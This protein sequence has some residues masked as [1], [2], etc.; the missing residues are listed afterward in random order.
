MKRNFV[1]SIII[2]ITLLFSTL[3]IAFADDGT[4]QIYS[5]NDKKEECL[6]AINVIETE[7]ALEG[8]SIEKEVQLFYNVLENDRI[9]QGLDFSED[10]LDHTDD[11]NRILE[12]VEK[13]ANTKDLN[14]LTTLEEYYL[15][16]AGAIIAWFNSKGYLLSAELL[17]HAFNNNTIYSY[18]YP[19]YGS[20]VTYSSVYWDIKNNA[21]GTSG[22]GTFPYTGSTYEKDL[23]YAI[24]N[25]NWYR[26]TGQFIISDLYDFA[27]DK[28]YWGSI[29]GVAVNL[30]YEAQSYGYLKPYYVRIYS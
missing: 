2:C 9:M 12:S 4:E 21:S 24:H 25:F 3:S 1:I 22:S 27:Q 14:S 6:Q 8:T 11:T 30:M 16:L 28:N 10:C 7:L 26:Q 13:L 18:Y 23:Y 15:G 29:A 17:D 20:R 5:Y 19:T